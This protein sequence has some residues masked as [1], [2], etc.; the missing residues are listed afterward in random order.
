M[1]LKKW[2]VPFLRIC[3]Y[4]KQ[5]KGNV[6]GGLIIYRLCHDLSRSDFVFCIVRTSTVTITH[7]WFFSLI[8]CLLK[9]TDPLGFLIVKSI[10]SINLTSAEY[11]FL[12]LIFIFGCVG[13]SLL[14]VGFSL[15]A[16][17]GATLRCGAQASHCG[18]FSCGA[19]A[20]GTRAS[21]VVA[22]GLSSCGT[23]ALGHRFSSCGAQV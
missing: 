21:V 14:R 20:L 4:M 5:N 9:R 3:V 15:V 7:I 2:Q 8:S 23:R 6:E 1:F 16:E 10:R 11:A 17:S 19:W 18:G 22:H 12:N 13:S